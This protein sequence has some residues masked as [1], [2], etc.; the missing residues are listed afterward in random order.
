MII[1]D[2]SWVI[3]LRDPADA[4][5]QTAVAIHSKLAMDDIR[6]HPVT[7]AECLVGPAAQDVLEQA[8]SALLDAFEVPAF[9]PDSPIR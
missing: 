4:H 9:D 6:L 8:T 3:A 1:A 2:A 5:H 7:F